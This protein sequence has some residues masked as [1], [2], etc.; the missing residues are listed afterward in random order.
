MHPRLKL[1][2][3]AVF[4]GTFAALAGIWIAALQD[5]G[6]GSVAAAPAGEMSGHTRPPGAHVPDYR[7]R[8]ADGRI[9]TPADHRGQVAIYAFV[10]AACED[11]CPLEVQQ[12]R[13]ALDDLGRDLPVVAVS[14]DPDGDT[15]RRARNFMLDQ[16]MTGRMRYLLGSREQLEPVWRA[17]GI[18]PQG[19]PGD[20]SAYVVV[21]DGAGRQRLGYPVSQL[22]VAGLARDLAR[23]TA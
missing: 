6:G 17:F 9:A 21:V 22:S 12:I 8:D 14:V 10:Y 3:V 13:G 16:R 2:V 23:L 19:S 15:P 7:L 4:A 11:V 18:A 20:H 5:G 1:V